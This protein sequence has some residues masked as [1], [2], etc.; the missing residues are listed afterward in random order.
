MVNPRQ[1]WDREED[2]MPLWASVLY[3][4]G[5]PS[6]IALGLVWL[7]ALKLLAGMD[8]IKSDQKQHSLMTAFYLYQICV[9]SAEQ[10]GRSEATCDP[11]NSGYN[12]NLERKP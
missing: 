8:D 12:F 4:V 11:H 10:S 6:A 2:G 1:K 3:K 7:M 5:V 9:A